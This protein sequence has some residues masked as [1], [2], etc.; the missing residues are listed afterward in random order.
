ML[1]LR[2]P[3]TYLKPRENCLNNIAGVVYFGAHLSA[4]NKYTLQSYD[5]TIS[6]G[7]ERERVRER[8]RE[9]EG[10]ERRRKK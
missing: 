7:R 5:W 4:E 9:R 6:R 3:C 10:E 2:S 1:F 8:E